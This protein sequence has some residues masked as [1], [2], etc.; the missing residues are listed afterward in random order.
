MRKMVQMVFGGILAL[1]IGLYAARGHLTPGGAFLGSMVIAGGIIRPFITPGAAREEL[2]RIA[3]RPMQKVEILGLFIFSLM[4]I[5]ML[6]AG[7]VLFLDW[8]AEPGTASTDIQ[9]NLGPFPGALGA[10]GAISVM[11][12]VFVVEMIGALS[13]IALYML[14]DIGRG[15]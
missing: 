8:L 3:G 4:A 1:I 5:V 15:M 13:L 10:A 6:A 12:L 9:V 2:V 11:D 14:S 7:A